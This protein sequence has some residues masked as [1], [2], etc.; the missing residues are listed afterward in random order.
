MALGY[1]FAPRETPVAAA[2]TDQQILSGASIYVHGILC[3]ATTAGAGTVRLERADGTLI[4]VIELLAGQS[5]EMTTKFN[6]DHGL[7]ITTSAN[8]SCVVFHSQAGA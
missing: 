5:F 1:E 7:Q 3:S 6:A 2:Q 8:V 4:H